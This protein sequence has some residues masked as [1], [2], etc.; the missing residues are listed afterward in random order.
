MSTLEK[1]GYALLALSLLT[2]WFR[3]V[4]A[5]AAGMLLG[6]LV[7]QA[8]SVHS[9]WVTY[10]LML[11]GLLAGAVWHNRSQSLVASSKAGSR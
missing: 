4:L 5:V 2:R 9:A 8:T 1:I 11:I 10:A 7:D 6:W 3:I